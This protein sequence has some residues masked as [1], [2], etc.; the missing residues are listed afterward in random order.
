MLL[1]RR[2]FGFT[3]IELLVV[4]AIIGLLIG[5]VLPAVQA[6]REAARATQCQNHLKQIS[7]AT[8]MFHDRVQA[9]PP[10]RYQTRPGEPTETACGGAQTTWLVRIMPFLEEAKQEERWDYSK[11]YADHPDDVR[12]RSLSTYCCPTR[13]SP[14]DAIGTGLVA[15]TTTTYIRLPCGCVVPVASSGSTSIAGA[16]GDYGGNHGDLSPGSA[17]L[18]SD[19]YYGGNGT[20]VIISSRA[21][22]V[23]NTPQ[24]WVDRIGMRDLIDGTSSTILA[25]EMHVPIGKLGSSPEDAFIYNGDSVYNSTR[26]GDRRCRS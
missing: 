2:R 5:L 24:D 13:R 14:S 12:V 17:G 22:C 11:D 25:G 7:L 9:F 23:S 20:G 15:A 26:L 19:F 10:A 1:D 8:S 4:I 6:A 16:L 18:P 21:R 3:L